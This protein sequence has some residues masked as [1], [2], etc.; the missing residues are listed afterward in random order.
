MWKRTLLA[1]IAVLGAWQILDMIIHSVF[2]GSTYEA[3]S[4]LWR[5]PMKQGVM[6]MVSIIASC[7]FVLIY[8]LLIQPKSMKNA[9]I[10]GLIYGIGGGIGMGYGTYSVMP[11]PYILAISWFL[12]TIVETLVAGAIVGWLIKEPAPAAAAAPAE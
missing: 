9:L 7:A 6:M 10:F 3:T 12:G 1:I 4:E 8:T 11:I 5:M 2:L